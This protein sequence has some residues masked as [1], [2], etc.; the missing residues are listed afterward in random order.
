MASY[1][2]QTEDDS[3][4]LE[5]QRPPT[6]WNCLEKT[7]PVI[8]G[9][10][11]LILLLIFIVATVAIFLH[12]KSELDKVHLLDQGGEIRYIVTKAYRFVQELDVAEVIE[13]VYKSNR[14]ISALDPNELRG[15]VQNA[16]TVFRGVGNVSNLVETIVS[17]ES[18]IKR[19]CSV[20]KC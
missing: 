20:L 16:T 1:S 11:N 17:T 15:V 8:L 7:L 5:S 3:L 12:Y 19:I 4:L 10:I 18:L 2:L 13:L 6:L 9:I 14:L